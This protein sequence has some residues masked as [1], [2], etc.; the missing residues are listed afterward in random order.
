MFSPRVSIVE[1]DD[2][3]EIISCMSL[4]SMSVKSDDTRGTMSPPPCLKR[5]STFRPNLV[6]RLRFI[7]MDLPYVP[8]SEESSEGEHFAPCDIH[9]KDL[10]GEYIT[11]SAALSRVFRHMGCYALANATTCPLPLDVTPKLSVAFHFPGYEPCWR[12][13]PSREQG[14]PLRMN[15]LAFKIAM[16]LKAYLEIARIAGQPFRHNGQD[17]HIDKVI[18]KRLYRV[19]K[20]VWQPEFKLWC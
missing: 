5:A 3:T 14:E 4:S 2:E 8:Y 16:E 9:F 13:V 18:L 12:Q 6:E 20:N 19:S 10:R 11:V 17:V 15:F 7:C 1:E